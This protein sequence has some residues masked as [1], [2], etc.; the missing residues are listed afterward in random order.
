MNTK[1]NCNA[2]FLKDLASHGKNISLFH[3]PNRFQ[4]KTRKNSSKL[5]RFIPN[6]TNNLSHASPLIKHPHPSH[7]PH[8]TK[9]INHHSKSSHALN[10]NSPPKSD[11][12]CSTASTGLSFPSNHRKKL[13]NITLN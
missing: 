4:Q 9:N 10:V 8:L 2:T 7:H 3:P 6:I 11:E 5:H 1:N 12:S 13:P